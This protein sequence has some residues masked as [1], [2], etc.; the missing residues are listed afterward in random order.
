MTP[1]ATYRRRQLF[2]VLLLAAVDEEAAQE[3][4]IP[5]QKKLSQSSRRLWQGKIRRGALLQP[6][7]SSFEV[8][9]TSGHDNALVTLCGFD[10]TSFESLHAPFRILFDDHSP[11]CNRGRS[12]R[13]HNKLKGGRRLIT[14]RQCLALVLAWTRTRGS[15]AVLQIIFGLTA[16]HLSLWMRFGRRLLLRVL[17]EDP[18]GAVVMPDHDE[19]DRFVL[20]INEK[21][22]ALYNCWGAMDGLKLCVEKAGDYQIQNLFFNGWQHDHYISN[23]FLFSPDG[24]IRVCYI[25]ATGTMHDSTMAKWGGV[26]DTIDLLFAESGAKIV[27]DSAFSSKACQSMFKSWQSNIDNQGYVRQNSQV[28]RQATS[29][30]QLSEWGMR[31]LQASFPRLKD[32]LMWKEKGERQLVLEMIV[33]LYNYCALV[34]GL[35]QI[36]SVFMPQLERSANRFA[37]V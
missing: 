34:V 20:S 5:F 25:N 19:I 17:Q 26:Y 9:F 8:L 29:V 23:L 13:Q 36:Q 1:P 7:Q 18:N 10:H 3:V 16:G 30:R 32:R 37:I 15:L 21:Y 6:A 31:G 28:Q 14:S 24:K 35:S 12:I 11:Y 4:E 27:V 33:Q 2:N 22:P